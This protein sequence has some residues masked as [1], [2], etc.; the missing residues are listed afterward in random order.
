M[1]SSCSAGCI[2][3]NQP[4]SQ[5]VSCGLN[6]KKFC[7]N[8]V[9]KTPCWPSRKRL[10]NKRGLRDAGCC[11]EERM[12]LEEERGSA[13]EGDECMQ[14]AERSVTTLFLDKL[15]LDGA[16]SVSHALYKKR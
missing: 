13:E 6:L 10:I 7:Q 8:G 1:G 16:A 12:G 15:C 2:C 14:S 3:M 9:R 5:V 4:S 11:L